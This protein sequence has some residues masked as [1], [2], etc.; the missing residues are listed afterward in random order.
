MSEPE[1]P[2]YLQVQ[3]VDLL[4]FLHE[5]N[6]NKANTAIIAKENNFFIKVFCGF[7]EAQKYYF[8]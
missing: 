5:A 3:E 2:L 7:C 6:D 4:D 8:F 1:I